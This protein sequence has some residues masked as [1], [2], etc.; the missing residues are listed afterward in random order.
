M[1]KLLVH[2]H[3]FYHEQI[4]FFVEKLSNINSCDWDLVVTYLEENQESFEKLKSLKPDVKLIQVENRGYDVW[5]FINIIKSTNLNEYDYVLKIHT[6]R[7][8]SYFDKTESYD[9]R[10]NLVNILLGNKYLFFENLLW[11]SLHPQIGLICSK[12]Y[13][14][15]CSQ[16]GSPESTY[17]LEQELQ[18]LK[19]NTLKREFCAGTMFFAKANIF[20]FLQSEEITKEDFSCDIVSGSCGTLAH[21]YERLLYIAVTE[22]GKKI[23]FKK[24]YKEKI[25]NF[26]KNLFSLSNHQD[27][28]HKVIT[29]LGLKFK[30]RS[31]KLQK[32]LKNE[33]KKIILGNKNEIVSNTYNDNNNK[34]EIYIRGYN[35]KIIIPNNLAITSKLKI[36]IGNIAKNYCVNN[37]I[38][39]I[40]KN[41][42]FEE[43]EISVNADNSKI[44]IG[45]D[46]MFARVLF[47]TGELHHLIFDSET[48]EYI[49]DGADI[50]I[51]NHVWCCDFSTIMK[52][53]KIAD[54][55]IV[56]LHAVVTGKFD[57]NNCVIAGI[58]AKVC[59]RN[60]HWERS[61]DHL[62][63]GTKY[64][65]SYFSKRKKTIL[66]KTELGE[67]NV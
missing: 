51:G 6:K 61:E 16:E 20:K 2:F 27:K 26:I 45:N 35:N 59:K 8:Y 67:Q 60:I 5:P 58:P 54:N 7:K 64:Y 34:L 55:N 36:N 19:F 63:A 25:N 21:V 46:N 52:N 49:D 39:E 32:K 13:K 11:L 29:I 65:E 47:R 28:K 24:T 3:L 37:C 66:D 44:K 42:S 62:I 38:I 4:D 23:Y 17:L 48:G 40:G 22:F 31:K 10:N 14:M 18:K 53:A 43:V 12:D 30:I 57:E 9:W 1:S 50:Q 41:C 33:C 56:G 15:E